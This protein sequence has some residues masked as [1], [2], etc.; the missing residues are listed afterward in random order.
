LESEDRNRKRR[1]QPCEDS[2]LGEVKGLFEADAF[3]VVSEIHTYILLNT[4]IF[5]GTKFKPNNKAY[6]SKPR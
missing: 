3:P 5:G 6:L 2:L 4:D 1:G